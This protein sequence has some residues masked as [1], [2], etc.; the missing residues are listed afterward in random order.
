MVRGPPNSI[1]RPIPSLD[2]SGAA[3]GAR[4]RQELLRTD[5]YAAYVDPWAAP[6]Q[7][8][9]AWR[10]SRARAAPPAARI[11]LS[12]RGDDGSGQQTDH[13]QQPKLGHRDAVDDGDLAHVRSSFT[14]YDTGYDT[15][16]E[17]V[18][19]RAAASIETEPA[20]QYVD[21]QSGTV[22]PGT[23]RNLARVANRRPVIRPWD[24]DHGRATAPPRRPSISSWA[25]T[26]SPAVSPRRD[27]A[28]RGQR[29][30]TARVSI[31]APAVRFN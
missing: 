2:A 29:W 28:D 3:G 8:S 15:G 16:G 26:K 4:Q 20:S 6:R 24:L 22:A 1:Q 27:L 11:R 7:R 31:S 25:W 9:R 30:T 23:G 5:N 19:A 18:R 10:T 21:P 12:R 17:Q 13:A 14:I